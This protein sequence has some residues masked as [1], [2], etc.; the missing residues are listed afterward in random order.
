MPI[1]ISVKQGDSIASLAALHGFLPSTLWGLPQNQELAARRSNMNEL[2]PGD[3]VYIPDRQPKRHAVASGRAHTFRQG[4]PAA[5]FRLR[6]A[7]MGIPRVEQDYTLTIDGQVREGTSDG[8]G[9]VEE[10]VPAMAKEGTLVIGPDEFELTLQFGHQ[11]PHDELS[12]IQKRLANL[13]YLR[14]EASGKLDNATRLAL[15]DFEARH[16]LRSSGEPSPE[17]L[18]VLIGYHVGKRDFVSKAERKVDEWSQE[19]KGRK[20]VAAVSFMGGDDGTGPGSGEDTGQLNMYDEP[21]PMGHYVII[22]RGVTAWY[23]HLTMLADTWGRARLTDRLPVMHLGFAEPWARRRQERMGQWPRMLDFFRGLRG[24]PHAGTPPPDLALAGVPAEDQQ[25]DWLPS[26]TFAA[27]LVRV[28]RHIQEQYLM[29]IGTDGAI[30]VNP[31]ATRRVP[32]I[33]QNGFV[34]TIENFDAWNGRGRAGYDDPDNGIP[35]AEVTRW[36]RARDGGRAQMGDGSVWHNNLCPYRISVFYADTH[37]FVYAMKIDVCT[38]PGQP[39]LF[40]RNFFATQELY[41]EHLPVFDREPERYD[42]GAAMPRIINGNDFIGSVNNPADTVLV[43]KGNPVGAQSV[44]SALD[45]PG[46]GAPVRRAWWVVNKSLHNEPPLPVGERLG[47]DADV[48]GRRNLL[49]QVGNDAL[50]DAAEGLEITNNHPNG[51]NWVQHPYRHQRFDKRFMGIG[52]HE[53][54]GF[55]ENQQN[56]TVSFNLHPYGDDRRGVPA[57]I[58]GLASRSLNAMR[59][60]HPVDTQYAEMVTAGQG[61]AEHLQELRVDRVV[62]SLGQ[63]RGPRS[64]G[65]AAYLVQSLQMHS[66]ALANFPAYVTDDQVDPDDPNRAAGLVRVL[67]SA[68]MGGPGIADGAQRQALDEGHDNHGR[69][70]PQEAPAGGGGMNMAITNIHRANHC[71]T[72]PLRVNFASSAELQQA[73]LSWPAAEH[74]VAARSMV[75]RGY[76]VNEFADN[77]ETF[78]AGVMGHTVGGPAGVAADVA[79]LRANGGN[80]TFRF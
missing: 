67:G 79:L 25:N 71:T 45:M 62:Y 39:R 51:A 35:A 52:F 14:E 54:S 38:G 43:F 3:R 72:G 69:T 21:P 70:V 75:D 44:Q 49:E 46:L 74:I 50:N 12:G 27:N 26:A 53:I 37:T 16:D 13:G 32:L 56:L 63:D 40:R 29:S 24:D 20:G 6:V 58:P 59:N 77:L 36:R 47:N 10:L 66:V 4:G 64:E 22:G 33:F 78:A 34:S 1:S 7:D 60:N 31:N 11:D 15:M 68:F 28:E 8:D 48:P 80:G 42:Q 5:R 65:T 17:S 55:A 41:D 19:P 73:G 9:I 76:T 57:H 61:Q 18:E 23:D 2:L 30:T